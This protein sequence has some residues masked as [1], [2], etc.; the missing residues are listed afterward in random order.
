MENLEKFLKKPVA[1]LYNTL[2][3]LL[4]IIYIFSRK[5]ILESNFDGFY[6]YFASS[7]VS[8]ASDPKNW[9]K[10]QQFAVDNNLIFI[11][12]VGPGYI[13]TNIRLACRILY[14]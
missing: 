1:T 13:D 5:E 6:T 10:Y 12:S 14:S 7:K 3:F 11:P 2:L 8:Q 9:N 4:T